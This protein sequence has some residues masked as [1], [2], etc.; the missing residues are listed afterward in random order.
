[1]QA[2][3]EAVNIFPG[4]KGRHVSNRASLCNFHLAA[5]LFSAV[6]QIERESISADDGRYMVCDLDAAALRGAELDM[7][8]TSR[9][10]SPYCL[11]GFILQ[12]DW[13]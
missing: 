2:H 4:K 1:M 12:G 11:T 10:L 9:C 5:V 6:P 7:R 13:Q 8:K 3:P